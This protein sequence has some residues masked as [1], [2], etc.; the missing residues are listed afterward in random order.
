V[1]PPSPRC[2]WNVERFRCAAQPK[3][4]KHNRSDTTAPRARIPLLSI[5]AVAASVLAGGL[6][7][8]KNV[9]GYA[10]YTILNV[11][12]D[13]TRELHQKINP[14]FVVRYER[15]TARPSRYASPTAVRLINSGRSPLG[16]SRQTWSRSAFLRISTVSQTRPDRA[17]LAST[18]ARKRAGLY[19]N[20]RLYRAQRQPPRDPRLA[21]SRQR[22]RRGYYARSENLWKRKADVT[23][24][25]GF[26]HQPRRIGGGR[27]RLR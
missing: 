11:S 2:D 24:G 25:L 23:G 7:A 4:R 3:L 14:A 9:N 22:Q 6:I 12:Y 5:A 20:R 26:R 21:R 18:S 10:A 1:R 8:A 15:E 16:A 17:G 27:Q 13:P 19:H